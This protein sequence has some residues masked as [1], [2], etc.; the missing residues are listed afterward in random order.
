MPN[1]T[2]ELP[3]PPGSLNRF[4]GGSPLA[5]ALRLV[6]THMSDDMLSRLH[7]LPYTA[8]EDGMMVVF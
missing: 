8:A 6:L 5:V 2:R 1:D 3:A 4:L 7:D